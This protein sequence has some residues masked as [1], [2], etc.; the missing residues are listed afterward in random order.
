MRVLAKTQ[1]IASKN[2]QI[3]ND[4]EIPS[5]VNETQ[6]EDSRRRWDRVVLRENFGFTIARLRETLVRSVRVSLCH[7]NIVHARDR[8]SLKPNAVSERIF[9]AYRLARRKSFRARRARVESLLPSNGVLAAPIFFPRVDILDQEREGC[10][11]RWSALLAVI[12]GRGGLQKCRHSFREVARSCTGTLKVQGDRSV[13]I[14][15][16]FD[17]THEYNFFSDL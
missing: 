9:K 13:E 12:L 6:R 2:L 10:H 1:F 3:T 7:R 11:T 15:S 4:D 16:K 8:T 14:G 17:G 5:R